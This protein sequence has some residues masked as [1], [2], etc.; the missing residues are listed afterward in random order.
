MII[1]RIQCIN[2]N[3]DNERLLLYKGYCSPCYDYQ[4]RHGGDQRPSRL[5]SKKLCSKCNN[6][7]TMSEACYL[8]KRPRQ[9][10][11][12]TLRHCVKCK[13]EDYVFNTYNVVLK[14]WIC[15]TCEYNISHSRSELHCT[16]CTNRLYRT[17]SSKLICVKCVLFAEINKLEFDLKKEPEEIYE[18]FNERMNSILNSINAQFENPS[19][20]SYI[21]LNGNLESSCSFDDFFCVIKYAGFGKEDRKKARVKEFMERPGIL[22]YEY[23]NQ[24]CEAIAKWVE[25]GAIHTLFERN[26]SVHNQVNGVGRIWGK[27]DYDCL[28]LIGILTLY[29]AYLNFD[30]QSPKVVYVDYDKNL[31]RF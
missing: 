3:C 22:A 9:T 16:V 26:P 2:P 17:K 12:I 10:I 15:Y 19:K 20:I 30:K 11:P 1:F 8:C 18:K 13:E 27:S 5:N 23:R 14:D 6:V 29:E 21:L 25:K 4:V 7:V 24:Q 31:F 28:K